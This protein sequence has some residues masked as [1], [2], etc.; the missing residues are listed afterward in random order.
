MPEANRRLGNVL[1]EPVDLAVGGID[2]ICLA[3]ERIDAR[4]GFDA[5]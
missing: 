5:G 4:M 3:A 2:G 1:G